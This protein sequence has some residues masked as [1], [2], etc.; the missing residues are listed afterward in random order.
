[1]A[2]LETIASG[3]AERAT[4]SMRRPSPAGLERPGEEPPRRP[5]RPRGEAP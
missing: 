5:D 2:S 1:M 3:I 4:Y